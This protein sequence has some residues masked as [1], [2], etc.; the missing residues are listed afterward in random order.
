[1]YR[2]IRKKV[3]APTMKLIEVE[4][5]DIAAKVL[6]GNFVI[7]RIDEKGERIPLTVADYDRKKGTITLIF[8]EV[9]YTTKHLGRLEEGD[10]LLDLVGP[11]GEHMQIEGYK[12]VICVGGGSGTALLYPKTK[13]FYEAGAKVLT[14]TGA[15]TKELLILLDELDA[16]SDELYVT[17]DDGSYGH[18]GFV[19]DILKELLDKHDDV[20]LVVAIGPVPMMKACAELTREYGVKC[21]VSLNAIMVDGTGMCGGCRVIVGGETKF[22]CVD[23]PAFDGHL[24]DFDDLMRRLSYYKK[25]EEEVLSNECCSGGECK[26]H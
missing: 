10:A 15:R 4:A 5:P 3:L 2:I 18:H 24:V 13:A 20:D 16:V 6:P 9:G 7:L 19:T 23:G 8:Q 1:M 17:T 14:I 26:C 21:I 22:T 11:L 25:H 12:K